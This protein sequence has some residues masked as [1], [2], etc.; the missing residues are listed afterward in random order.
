MFR[1]HTILLVLFLLPAAA[2]TAP[3]L[4]ELAI[5]DITDSDEVQSMVVRDANQ[6]VLLVISQVPD[7]QV[8]SNNRIIEQKWQASGRLLIKLVPGTHRLTFQHA[9]Y[10]AENETIYFNAK[11]A[12]GRKVIVRVAPS[13]GLT[14]AQ[15]AQSGLLDIQSDPEGAELYV[16]DELLG[17]TPYS[18][19]RLS[20][21][22]RLHLQKEFYQAS[23]TTVALA[24]NK[25]LS[26]T[27]RLRPNFGF[28]EVNSDPAGASVF[29]DDRPVGQ[30]PYSSKRLDRGTYLV[31]LEKELYYRHE[32]PVQV[33]VDRTKKVNVTLKAAF[34]GI[35]IDSDP[36]GA[37][38]YIDGQRKGT[39]PYRDEQLP[40]GDYR[41]SLRKEL[42]RE[43]DRR[44]TVVDGRLFDEKF[45]LPPNFAEVDIRAP[46]GA[47]IWIDGQR[48]G[49]G[50][51]RTRLKAGLH[52]FEARLARHNPDIQSLTLAVGATR[53]I[54]LKPEPRTGKVAVMVEPRKGA[55]AE[56]YLD[57]KAMG[58]AP[59][60]LIGLLEGSYELEIRKS[61]YLPDRRPITVAYEQEQDVRFNLV[62]YSGS[63]QAKKDAWGRRRNWT[64]AATALCLGAG[65]FTAYLSESRY[66]SYL[67][68]TTVADAQAHRSKV[69]SYETYT[70][71]SLGTAGAFALWSLYNQIRCSTIDVPN[72]RVSIQ[73]DPHNQTIGLA[74]RF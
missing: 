49:S 6:A 60:L 35:A 65:G 36:S 7:L 21:L 73:V 8:L 51:V 69:E 27:L 46:Q 1:K 39:T 5:S 4:G 50:T 13:E 37:E 20:G 34:G 28:I 42:Y 70:L 44:I 41:L 63:Q 52:E 66:D 25:T 61:G 72:D 59:Q 53:Q 26:L 22:L 19:R 14:Q 31:K 23:D 12:K 2:M 43:I 56:I 57:G 3:M 62:T 47:E 64:L 67:Q 16:N 48:A 54:E 40:S 58:P 33:E 55:S 38:V 29:I 9:D 18:G 10:M 11:E 68:A 32:E 71:A 30:T 15:Q 17:T 45:V 24:P 74:V